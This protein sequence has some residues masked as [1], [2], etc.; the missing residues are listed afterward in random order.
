MDVFPQFPIF[1]EAPIYGKEIQIE[2]ALHF[3]LIVAIQAIVRKNLNR[4]LGD[5]EVGVRV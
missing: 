2:V 3:G 1:L 4:L 5:W